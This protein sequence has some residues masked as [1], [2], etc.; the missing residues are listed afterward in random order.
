MVIT[1]ERR[2]CR[3]STRVTGVQLIEHQQYA[4]GISIC[5]HLLLALVVATTARICD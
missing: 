2:Y 4:A 1:S 5:G 3:D